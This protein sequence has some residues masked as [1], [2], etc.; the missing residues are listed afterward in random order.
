VTVQSAVNQHKKTTLTALSGQ[1]SSKYTPHAT[2][3]L[4]TVVHGEASL[5]TAASSGGH[6]EKQN[7]SRTDGL[8][9]R[10]SI[11]TTAR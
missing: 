4:R 6:V 8:L 7:L 2:R 11:T 10:K 3:L 5:W 9:T 1:S